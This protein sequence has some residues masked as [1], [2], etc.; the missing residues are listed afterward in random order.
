MSV[1]AAAGA[2]ATTAHESLAL[3]IDGAFV[4]FTA[5]FLQVDAIASIRTS[6]QARQHGL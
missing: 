4:A 5:C 3:Y 2:K 6:F 1:T